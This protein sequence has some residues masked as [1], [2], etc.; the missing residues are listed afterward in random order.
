MVKKHN[1]IKENIDTYSEGN[2]YKVNQAVIRRPN[3]C[4]IQRNTY[5]GKEKKLKCFQNKSKARKFIREFVQRNPYGV[6]RKK[7]V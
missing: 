6:S 2:Y 1:W 5:T 7:N 3:N 4:V